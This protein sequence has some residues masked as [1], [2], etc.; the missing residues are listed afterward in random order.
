MTHI[1]AEWLSSASEDILALALR[2]YRRLVHRFPQWLALT[3]GRSADVRV[4]D[5][6]MPNLVEECGGAE[7][8]V[9]HLD[10]LDSCLQSCGIA[11]DQD[12]L[13][14]TCEIERWFVDVLRKEDTTRALAVLG[15]GTEA[16]AEQFLG[17]LERGV[18]GTFLALSPDLR[19]FDVHR[20]ERERAHIASIDEAIRY[21]IDTSSAIA[22]AEQHEDVN[23]WAKR[24]VDMHSR[25]WAS[26]KAAECGL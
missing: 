12:I 8:W 21:L 25:F 26:L 1:D 17:P 16:V 24:T 20:P 6:L 18:R 5:L 2:N 22:R 15:P 14:S 13:P 19:Y 4:R 10:L 9:S 11:G 7:P 23:T 3:I